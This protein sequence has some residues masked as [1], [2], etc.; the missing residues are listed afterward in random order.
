M[1]T[2]RC[3]RPTGLG[4]RPTGVFSVCSKRVFTCTHYNLLINNVFIQ[5]CAVCSTCST[6]FLVHIYTLFIFKITFLLNLNNKI[7][8]HTAHI[9]VYAGCRAFLPAHIAAHIAAHTPVTCT[10]FTVY[11]YILVY[12]YSEISS[13]FLVASKH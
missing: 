13:S 6:I 9:N 1:L 10:H 2:N 3:P 4:H 11:P 8:E 12:P 7:D 5:M